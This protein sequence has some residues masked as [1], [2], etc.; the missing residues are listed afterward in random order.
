MSKK[1][2]NE[3]IETISRGELEKYQLEKLKEQITAAYENSPAYRES[4]DEAGVTP[5]DLK[6]L[7]DLRKFP[8]LTKQRVR[9]RQDKKPILGD[10]VVKP[11]E[12]VVFISS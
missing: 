11:E 2:W 10:L 4:F 8:I 12:D 7:D 1:F 9:E 6:T 3:K 5:E